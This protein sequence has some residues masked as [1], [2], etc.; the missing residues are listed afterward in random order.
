MVQKGPMVQFAPMTAPGATWALG[1]M[2]DKCVG[3]P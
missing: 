1:W 3:D 2:E